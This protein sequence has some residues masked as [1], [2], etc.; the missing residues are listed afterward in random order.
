MHVLSQSLLIAA[1][2]VTQT[3]QEVVLTHLHPGEA[4]DVIG[5]KNLWP[6]SLPRPLGSP[7]WQPM[8]ALPTAAPPGGIALP[9]SSEKPP[10]TCYFGKLGRPPPP[11]E[12]R[13]DGLGSL[14][15][16]VELL[17]CRA[18]SEKDKMGM[19]AEQGWRQA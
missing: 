5:A 6:I 19:G 8:S 16:L 3:T 1:F 10:P 18:L 4:M 9:T 11:Q 13:T 7:P 14:P 12:L 2:R 15:S 17:K